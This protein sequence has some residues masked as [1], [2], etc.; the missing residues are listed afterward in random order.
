M[1]T[2]TR[3]GIRRQPVLVSA[4]ISRQSQARVSWLPMQ[5]LTPSDVHSGQ[6]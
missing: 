2:Y 1:S 4:R 3:S 6:I 5:I